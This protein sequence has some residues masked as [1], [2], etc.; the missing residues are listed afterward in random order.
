ML[1]TCLWNSSTSYGLPLTDD[2]LFFFMSLLGWS[3]TDD[4]WLVCV[5][6]LRRRRRKWRAAMQLFLCYCSFRLRVVVQ[7]VNIGIF[8]PTFPD[9]ERVTSSSTVQMS[10]TLTWIGVASAVGAVLSGPL[11]DKFNGHGLLAAALLAQGVAIGLAPWCRA[12]IGYQIMSATACIFNFA[13]M[14]GKSDAYHGPTALVLRDR[15]R[16]QLCNT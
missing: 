14:C 5:N 10:T 15:E 4:A 2:S 3:M 12:L 6:K 7:G 1:Q 11:F 13:I 8:S 16:N 9:M